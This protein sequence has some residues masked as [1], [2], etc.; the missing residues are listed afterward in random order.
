MLFP[1][2]ILVLVLSR[3]CVFIL[4]VSGRLRCRSGF[5][6]R[7]RFYQ[8][9][10]RLFS[11]LGLELIAA[12]LFYINLRKNTPLYKNL[13]NVEIIRTQAGC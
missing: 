5:N 7:Q 12:L 10:L 11:Y 2:G 9:N 8:R 13:L 6:R 4:A 3:G 1:L